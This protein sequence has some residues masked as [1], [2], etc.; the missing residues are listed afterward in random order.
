MDDGTSIDKINSTTAQEL[1]EKGNKAFNK[2]NWSEALNHYTNALKLKEDNAEK[3]VYYKNRAAAYLKL[4]D[5]EKVVEDCDS[6]LKICCNKALY[7]RCQ[8]LEAVE[9]LEEA[10]RDA[11]IIILSDPNNKV[12]QLIAT[13]L[14]GIVQERRKKSLYISEKVS[15]MLDVAFNVSADKE[16]RET[17][18]HNLLVLACKRAGAEDIFK[19]E[20]VSK[21]AQLVVVERNEEMICSAIRIVG[22][23]CQNNISRT[24]SVVEHVGLLW[25]L[26]MM[27][28]TYTERV[29]ASQYCLQN[30]LN[31]YSRMSKEPDS[32]PDDALCETHK[33]EIDTILSCLLNSVTSRTITGLAR[34]AIIQLIMRNIHCVTALNWTER[35]VELR[36]LQKLIEVASEMEEY[37][38]ESPMDVTFSTR[39]IISVC[40]AKIYEN[41][42]CDAAK[43]KFSNAINEFINDKLLSPNTEFKVRVVVA[44]TTLLFGPL[45]V[46]NAIIFKEGMIEMILAMA[47]TD[48][49]LEQKV[50]CECIVAAVTK[51]NE[52]NVFIC[53]GVNI[54]EKLYQSE[55]DSVRVRAL[56]GLCKLNRFKD[57]RC[58]VAIDPFANEATKTLAKICRRF[59]INP[60]KEKD[61][62]KWAIK[63]LSYLTCDD[64]VKEEFIEDQEAI[65]AMIELTKIDD[66]SILYDVLTTLVNLCNAYEVQELPE[67]IELTE[68]ADQYFPERHVLADFKKRFCALLKTGVTSALVNLTKTDSQNCKELIARVFRVICAE[69]ESREIV[70]EQGGTKALLS[71]ALDGTDN[72]KKEASRA[73]VCLGLTI[74]PEVAFPGQIIMEVVRPIMN[75]LKPEC[76]FWENYSTL[77]V[78][79]DLAKV[80]DNMREHISKEE[81]FQKIE[82]YENDVLKFGSLTLITELLSNREVAI[83]YFKQDNSRIKYLMLLCKDENQNVSRSAASALAWLTA[84]NEEACKKVFNS[85]TWLESLRFLLINSDC[86]IRERGIIIVINM[87]RSTTDV[88]AKLMETDLM[89][90][91]R[92]LS[93]DDTV[94]NKRIKEMAFIAL[95]DA[96]ERERR[97][98]LLNMIRLGCDKARRSGQLD[99]LK[100]MQSELWI[101]EHT[102]YVPKNINSEFARLQTRGRL[103]FE[104]ETKNNSLCIPCFK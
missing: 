25:C 93:K 58:Y 80:N 34:D 8:A 79:C 60:K 56:V 62:R 75:L 88:A 55:N 59:L 70:V 68:F 4:R 94:Q 51:Y 41:V 30:I 15:Q 100:I 44:I 81:V 87:I 69:Q 84:A 90:L 103:L 73:L 2:G 101:H 9:R 29:N 17:A 104:K 20:G 102:E 22:E 54:L 67:M 97:E 50:V 57:T 95:E 96:A 82:A 7:R 14:L 26:E 36:G 45:D 23:L 42:Y 28:S 5:Y 6:A 3:G 78:L 33:N 16:N 92:S 76:S 63:G 1:K 65:Q 46:T 12:I 89:E 52:A 72:G 40:L 77:L 64:R 37:K 11:E 83:Q 85:N 32:K 74:R 43:E 18:M 38:C 71:L 48:D 53:R 24:E 35:I 21:I 39:A 31:S 99:L 19:K 47:E 66:Q 61:M 27:N 98:A 86:D 10:Y 13:R 91:L 49:V